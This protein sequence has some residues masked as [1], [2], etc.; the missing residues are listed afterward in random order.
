MIRTS[1]GLDEELFVRDQACGDDAP[2]LSLS[3]VESGS[4]VGDT[5]MRVVQVPTVDESTF[6]VVQGPSATIG[7]HWMDVETYFLPSVSRSTTTL[8]PDL[9]GIGS[10]WTF[11]GALFVAFL[12]GIG[13]L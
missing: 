6:G 10:I 5:E 3:D 9:G 2:D 12:G 11:V 7:E 13:W 4:K 1:L 8:F